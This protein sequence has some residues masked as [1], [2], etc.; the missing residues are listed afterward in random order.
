L[1]TGAAH[2]LG[3]GAAPA[4]HHRLGEHIITGG[5]D[6]DGAADLT[7]KLMGDSALGAR[8]FVL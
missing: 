3:G 1:F 4:R 8:S 5:I 7:I 2:L 6:G